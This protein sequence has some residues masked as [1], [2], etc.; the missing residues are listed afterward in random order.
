MFYIECSMKIQQN[1]HLFPVW[2]VKF[3]HHGHYF[4]SCG[5]DKTVKLWTT[6]QSACLRIFVGHFS[7]VDCIAFHPN[8]NYVASGSSDRSVRLW[9]CVTGN[10]VRLMT[11]HKSSVSTVVFSHDGRFLV[12]GGCDNHVLIWDIAHGHLLGDF[13]HHTAMVS[14]LCFSRCSNVLASASVDCSITLW[15]FS[16]FT[17][18]CN[19]EEVNVTHNPGV[20]TDSTNMIITNF[21][22]KDSPCLGIH[23]TRRNLL[24]GVGASEV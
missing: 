4:V 18:D 9:D 13:A 15:N 6:E 14:S 7:D 11:G 2:Q 16:K 20:R 3:S 12:T 10:C 5:H 24:I 21:R 17:S 8:S 22:T 23:F 19:L 1:A